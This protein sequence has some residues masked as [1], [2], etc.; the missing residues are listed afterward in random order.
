MSRIRPA[1]YEQPGHLE[2]CGE[3]LRSAIKSLGGAE[4]HLARRFSHDRSLNLL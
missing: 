3:F 4:R 1:R 2:K